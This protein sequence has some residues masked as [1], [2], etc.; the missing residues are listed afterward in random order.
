MTTK[1]K[2]IGT[3]TAVG[4]YNVA[5]RA[6]NISGTGNSQT[7]TIVIVP[8]NTPDASVTELSVITN[9][10]ADF[11]ASLLLSYKLQLEASNSPLEFLAT[12]LPSGLSLA[13]KTGIISGVPR[14]VGTYRPK[15]SVRNALGLGPETILTLNVIDN[16]A[17]SPLARVSVESPVYANYG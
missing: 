12:D 14:T 2:I 11:E 16:P 10:G 3:P 13:P 15:I 5:I 9:S 8:A 7:I 6:R 4:T 17:T 1:A